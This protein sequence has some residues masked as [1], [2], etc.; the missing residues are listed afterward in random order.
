M[1]DTGNEIDDIM[2]IWLSST[3]QA[4]D[5][6][7]ED[8]WHKSYDLVKDVYLPQSETYVYTGNGDILG[9]ISI[10]NK[11]FIGAIFIKKEHQGK[12]IGRKLIE[13]IKSHYDVLSLAV[14]KKNQNAVKFYINR[15]FKYISEQ[16]NEDTKE[17]EYIMSTNG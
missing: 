9:F 15:D 13:F 3:I 1:N 5:F 7:P 11:E 6:I 12:G 17:P 2:D 10:I 8:Y 4:H 16:L 14:Y